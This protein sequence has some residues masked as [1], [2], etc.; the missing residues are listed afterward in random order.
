M[1]TKLIYSPHRKPFFAEILTLLYLLNEKTINHNW[2]STQLW[3]AI[4]L[5]LFWISGDCALSGNCCKNIM[6]YKQ[7][8]A[9]NNKEFWL[10][11]LKKEKKYAP[12]YPEYKTKNAKEIKYFNC[13][14]LRT[15][16]TCNNYSNRPD[17][18]KNY[19]VSNFISEHPLHT[20]CGFKINKTEKKPLNISKDL[21]KKIN[22]FKTVFRIL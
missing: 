1:N 18:C 15:D 3:D 12:F 8:K 20:S 16:N 11:I 2:L 9:I 17:F 13:K 5:E 10:S 4:K 6:L 22:H 19:P 21:N 7:R 14:N